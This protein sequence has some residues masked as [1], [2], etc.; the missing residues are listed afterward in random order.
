MDVHLRDLRYF[1]AVA[2]ELHF[3]NAA[4]RLHVSQPALSKQIRQLERDL[5]FPLFDRDHRTV[6]LTDA[7]EALLEPAGDLLDRWDAANAEAARRARLAAAVLRVGFQTSVAGALYRL[8][9]TRFTAAHAGWRVELKLHPWSD[10]TAGLLLQTSDVAFLWLPVPDQEHLRFETLRV[11]PRYVALWRKHPLAARPQLRLCEL[12]DE[13]FVALPPT[14]GAQRDYWLALD[15]RNGHPVRIG[16]QVESPDETF[17]AVAAKQG[18]T[19]LSAG[20]AELYSR[21]GIVSRPVV[22]LTPAELAIAWRADDDRDVLRDF[23]Q[24]AHQAVLACP[25]P[26]PLH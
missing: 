20:N 13:P 5:G 8:A 19:F 21:P 6:T 2:E 1:L 9:V 11:E 23:A 17:E 12:L 7:G 22:D 10:P 16:A 26:V 4:E 3:T 24:A 14:A 18:L 15:Q 25:L